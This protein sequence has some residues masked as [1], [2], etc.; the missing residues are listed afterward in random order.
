MKS[1]LIVAALLSGFGFGHQEAPKGDEWQSPG[2][3]SL[4]KEL[5]HAWFFS[6]TDVES[7]RKVLPENSTLW[8]SLDGDWKF[9]WAP[10]PES[11]PADFYKAGYD[12]SSWADIPVPS[13]WNIVGIGEDGSQKYGTPIYVNVNV[14]WFYVREPGDWKKGV[15][16]EPPQ[17]WTTYKTRNEVGSYRRTFEVPKEWAGKEIFMNFD[18]VDSFF[19][20]WINGKYVGFSKNSRNLA[21][22]DITEYLREDAENVVAVEV[23]RYSDAANLEAQDMFRLPGIFRSVALEAKPK[24]SVRDIKVTSSMTSLK[25]DASVLDL[26]S[27][28]PERW[29]GSAHQ[30]GRN[31]VPER[32]RRAG[33]SITYRLY[34]NVLYSDEN[35]L[36]AE[37]PAQS[38][39]CALDYPAAKP[40]SAEAP[41]R[42]T[43]VGEL[44][45][46]SGKTLD[47]F[48]TI[49]GFREV[50]IKDTPA[51]EDEFGLAGKYFYLNGKPVKLRG[52][53]RH[54]TEPSMGHAITREVMEQ[55]I[56]LMKR[57]NI[58]H[59][60][61]S[62][63]TD[64]PY[65]YYLCDKYGI[66]LMDEANIESH[67]YHYGDASL[68]HPIEWKD[69]HVARM[70]EMVES[71]Y[72]H[73][74]IIIWSMGNEAG[75][76][77][78]FEYV[79]AA[80][81]ALDPM[82]PIQYERNNNISDIGCSQYPG[83]KWVQAVA[84]GT[85]N[86]K[87]PYHINEFAHSMG[88][89]LGNFAQYWQS[90]DSTNF[91]MGGAI[92]DWVDQSLWNYT[93]EGV[94]YLASGGNFGDY[95]ND[96]QFVMNGIINGDRSPKPQYFEV[97]K[98]YQ[99]LY[100]SLS[101]VSGGVAKVCLFNRN[102]YEPCSYDARWTLIA[103]GKE[104]RS[105][106]FDAEGIGPREKVLRE[107]PV[108]DLP[109]GKEC[110]L[111]VS[112]TQKDD[113]F[114]AEKGYEVCKDQMY[115]S[116]VNAAP[117][118]LSEAKDLKGRSPKH[119]T[120]SESGL[121]VVKGRRFKVEFNPATGTIETLRYCGKDVFVPGQG[122]R[123][124]AFRAIVNNDGWA[125][126]GWFENGLHNLTHTASGMVV[127]EKPG[128]VQ[129][130]FEVK[131]KAPFGSH[132]DGTTASAVCSIIDDKD[133]LNVIE[134]TSHL[135]W[136]VTRKGSVTLVSKITSDNPELPLGRLGYVMRVPRNLSDFTYYGRGPVENYSDRYTNAFV[137]IY[138]SPVA[139]QVQNY[140]K[141]QDMA[142][143]EQV[144]WASLTGRRG[145][146]VVF[147]ACQNS[148]KRSDSGRPVMSV[149][150][151]PYSA[152]DL[153][154]AAH[155]NELPAP[156]DTWLCLDAA[157]SG[158]GG[159]SC[160]PS[161]LQEDRVHSDATFGFTIR[162]K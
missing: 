3:L 51:A 109:E 125:Y 102:Y 132:L 19:Y 44:K 21:Q 110:Y 147:E 27:S 154:Q 134:F 96:G 77:K 14:P 95:P 10:D 8:K 32:S 89:A 151:L 161:P 43:L 148:L 50:C 17:K 80:A 121:L 69:A 94:K 75:P 47:I 30:P 61:N 92:W 62:H 156:G 133:S 52:V 111:N 60:R 158:L 64:A 100:T 66:Y 67:H 7:A 11:R 74:S 2:Q 116:P 16:R 40:W 34:E 78:N 101:G 71:N 46:A 1:L 76:G 131:S 91:F 113:L 136:T 53:N 86:V 59:V 84:K 88:N 38:L 82:R 130:S 48:S 162:R 153:V 65:W 45:D 68:S 6:F 28:D 159:N 63:Y 90:I 155:Q 25:V 146:G 135:T 20:L 137:G 139:D 4:N 160:G 114:W 31:A 72:N 157:D 41:H 123:L 98:V 24:V 73:P 12:D 70:V 149:N 23:Y 54:E 55:D 87:Y 85:G 37:F 22:F 126:R 104:V 99:N 115:I 97:K 36:V 56:R 138:S 39:S 93:S 144:R 9:N 5:P 103:D 127:E 122:P 35:E 112:Y 57:A 142:N 120:D 118:I 105:G 129:V 150:A 128:C 49:V 117:V 26:S 81:R 33:L 83:V 108:G 29:F 119:F 58:N 140:T 42:Y 145:R 79:Y 141:S 13:N 124:N 107:I 18:G 143:H 106:S 15:M 152:V